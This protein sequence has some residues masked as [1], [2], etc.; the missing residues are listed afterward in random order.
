VPPC[1][2]IAILVYARTVTRRDE[3]AT[4]AALGASRARIVMQVFVEVL[5]LASLS[6][7]AGFLV[8][9]QFAV[10]LPRLVMPGTGPDGIPFWMDFTPSLATV[11]S[12]AGLSALA[13]VMAGAIPAFHATGGW[14][15]GFH[16]L[17][18]RCAGASLG[19]T[20]TA[21]LAM[22]VALSL[23]ILPSGIEMAWGI[24]RPAIAGLSLSIEQFLT[25]QLAM[26]GDASRL[27]TLRAEAVKRLASE[28]GVS[29][30]TMSAALLMQE[31]F[32][33]IQVEGIVVED[34]QVRFNSVDDRYFEVFAARFLAGRR[35]EARDVAPAASAVIVNRS[36]VREIVG[37]SNALGRRV[38]Y[39]ETSETG[40]A[41][42]PTT[43]HEIVGIVE[44]FPG[45]NDGPIVYHPID[46]A[47][48]LRIPG[49]V[50]AS[51][52]LMT[53][54]GLLAVAGPARRAV[55]IDPTEALRVS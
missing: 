40:K 37:D 11:V 18:L 51:A 20:W 9:R 8:A 25:G 35:F 53:V 1:A 23:A 26:E 15:S 45:N 4:R 48:G 42:L 31:P 2:N 10:R 16:A 33:D 17:G 27:A 54:V 3:F 41:A 49:V 47:G 28:S 7:I 6:G 21:L 22:Q 32:A 38:R 55:R 46:E 52:A 12:V 5:V 34:N 29:G 19:R 24:F 30:V 13:A 50:A 14:K 39:V 43:W 44:D 36:F